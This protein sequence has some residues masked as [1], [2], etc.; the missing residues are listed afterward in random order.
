MPSPR[1]G[2]LT[3]RHGA[4]VNG[5]GSQPTGTGNNGKLIHAT[6]RVTFGLFGPVGEVA[7]GVQGVRILGWHRRVARPALVDRHDYHQV[8]TEL[9][10]V[11]GGTR[12]ADAMR[13]PLQDMLAERAASSRP[14][15]AVST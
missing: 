13:L 15:S 6:F 12:A 3:F 4:Q 8:I 5:P 11:A 1:S 14:R 7:A 9:P 10:R 2:K